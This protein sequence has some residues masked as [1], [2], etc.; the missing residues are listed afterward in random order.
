MTESDAP[1]PAG[2]VVSLAQVVEERVKRN[3]PAEVTA[4]QAPEPV[5]IEETPADTKVEEPASEAETP[6][7]DK[8]E[9][10][11]PE[12]ETP[13]VDAPHW[14]TAEQKAEWS[15]MSPKH[16]AIVLEQ[17]QNRERAVSKAKQ[18]AAEARKKAEQDSAGLGQYRQAVEQ[19]LQSASQTFKSK[20]EGVDWAAWA[21]Q[22]PVA[23]FQG[24]ALYDKEATEL[25]QL[26]VARQATE[27][28]THKRH[29]ET[30]SAKLADVAP[31]LVD[32][33]KGSARREEVGRFLIQSG[34]EAD[35]LKWISATEMG[36]AYDA[37]RYR[38]LQQKA[39]AELTKPKTPQIAPKPVAP[40]AAAQTT[41][42]Q[43][44]LSELE[45]RARRTGRLEDTLAYREARRKAGFN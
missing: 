35:Q 38:Q 14:W 16:Q 32:P 1:T 10:E 9:A 24:K 7:D 36:L 17:E 42:T 39:K 41:S 43:S 12:P 27:T 11:T 13:A 33:E 34:I 26:D 37:M 30:E 3:A 6:G 8:A 31:D 4:A 18:E 45:A 19:A 29:L 20:W 21:E 44:R 5:E 25:Q 28:L 22:D 40:A 15:E 2:E 23:A